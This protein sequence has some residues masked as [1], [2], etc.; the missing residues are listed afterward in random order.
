MTLREMDKGAL[1]RDRIRGNF[2]RAS[3]EYARFE[4]ERAFF[5]RLTRE[6]LALAPLARGARVLDVGCGTGAS[7]QA[8]TAAVGTE[9]RAVGLDLSL[10]MLREARRAL[11]GEAALVAADGC[12]FGGTF[13]ED[14]DAVLYNAV[15]FLLP[16][17]RASLAS[18]HQVLRPGGVVLVA[19]LEGAFARGTGRPVPDLLAEQGHTPGRHA[20]SPW[21]KVLEALGEFFE[22]PV[23]RR[24]T[25][26]LDAAAFR[27]FYS[28]E[29]MSAGL[30]PSLPYPE[31]RA[32]VEALAAAWEGS[33]QT[34]DQV[35]N[36]ASARK[37]HGRSARRRRDRE[38]TGS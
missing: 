23:V 20:L 16:D 10:G 27:A 37:P 21:P 24:F 17:A 7:L 12:S 28:M 8:L 14:F 32:A 2:D 5:G 30:L 25:A 11:G 26:S 34:I 9:G 35:W 18:A 36:L 38:G 3:G 31:R 13:R 22:P 29:P 33:G 1:L 15:L 19:N 4:G 6:A